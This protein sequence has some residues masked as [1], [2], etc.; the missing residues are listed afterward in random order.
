VQHLPHHQLSYEH[1]LA[2]ALTAVASGAADAAIL[3]R[4]AAISQIALTAHGGSR[5]PPKTTFFWP[6]PRTGMV[7]R[8]LEGL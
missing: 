8:D 5:M 2:T 4:P 7:L 1:D 3:C 6:K